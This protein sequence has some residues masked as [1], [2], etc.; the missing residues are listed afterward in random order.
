MMRDQWWSQRWRAAFVALPMVFSSN[1]CLAFAATGA[2]RPVLAED[3]RLLA[4]LQSP[5]ISPD[6]KRIAVVVSR[7]IWDDDRRVR[8][9][10][11][12]D[13]ATREV[14][15]LVSNLKG[16]SSP[17]F[18]PDGKQLAFLAEAKRGD[19]SRTQIF[20]LPAGG[21]VLRQVTSSGE[22]VDDFA[23]RPDGRAFVY[24]AADAHPKRRGADRFRDSFI[25]TTEP[26]VAQSAPRPDHLFVQMLAGKTATQLTFGMQSDADAVWSPD[27]GSIAFTCLANAILNDEDASH[28]AL[29]DVA[30]RATRALTGRTMREG[31]PLFSPDGSK[32]AYSY[33]DGD[34]QITPSQEWVTTPAGGLGTNVSQSIDRP[35]GDAVWSHDSRSLILTAPSGTTNALYRVALDGTVQPISLGELTPGIPLNTTGGAEVPSLRNAVALGGTLAF[36]AT[37]TAQ[38]PEIFTLSPGRSPMK[39]SD[40]N[41]GMSR[42]TWS[43]AQRVTFPTGTGVTGDGVLYFPPGFQTGQRYPLMVYIHGGP[44]DP[45]LMTFDFWAQVMAAHGWLVLRPN[46]RG[47]PNLGSAYQHA[48]LYDPEDGPGKDIMSAVNSIRARGIVDD[49]RIAVSG[50]SYGGIMTAWLISKYHIW[51]AAVSGASVNDWI[52][53]Y[54][55]ADDSNEDL[56]LLHGSPF[57]D[58]N[59][60]EWRTVSAITYAG[61]V[62]TPVLILSDVGDNRDPFATSAMYWRALRDNHKDATLRAWPVAAH[63]PDDPVRIVDIYHYW[64]DYV[65]QHFAGVARGP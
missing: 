7:V 26:I 27:G 24:A 51:K 55:T 16:L 20:V 65:V 3:Y 50:W 40:F 41:A 5:A 33:T 22:D 35:I 29:V 14:T 36:A 34:S 6:A 52:A 2:V 21:G 23:W 10:E 56:A 61:D 57:V 63:F 15:T 17:V 12:I 58:G 60:A 47:S 25:F 28:V 8:T 64:I 1:S 38:P 9:L 45:T 59:S 13:V 44:G 18:S 42:F 49:A 43:N 62:T 32:I 46:Y 30:T 48:I 4:G 37:W 39:V 53:D 31:Q 54:G 19:A 11:S